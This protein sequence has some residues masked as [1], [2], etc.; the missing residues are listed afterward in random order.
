MGRC[1]SPHFLCLLINLIQP[2]PFILGFT[3]EEAKE[4]LLNAL[5]DRAAAAFAHLNTINAAYWGDLCGSPGHK[6]FVSQV[7]G[8]AGQYLLADFQAQVFRQLDDSVAGDA[9]QRG[10]GERLHL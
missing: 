3:G 9:R 2:A 10:R 6:D 1:V 5:G 4:C 8:L 7:Q